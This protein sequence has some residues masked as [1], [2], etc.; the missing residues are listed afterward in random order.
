M[1]TPPPPPPPPMYACIHTHVGAHTDTHACT[2]ALYTNTNTFPLFVLLFSLL[3]A[4]SLYETLKGCRHW[5]AVSH[6]PQLHTEK[7][8]FIDDRHA[9]DVFVDIFSMDA[10]M[11]CI[12]I[13]ALLCSR[14]HYGSVLQ[15]MH[16][17]CLLLHHNYWH[18]S[19]F[20][21]LGRSPAIIAVLY[22][23]MTK[24]CTTRASAFCCS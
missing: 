14:N 15:I 19:Q 1:F 8:F 5:Q 4:S 11:P 22:K 7:R 13:K 6:T 21:C 24:L 16:I 17:S 20:L 23:K 3:P 2:H 18:P 12:S 10:C 9:S